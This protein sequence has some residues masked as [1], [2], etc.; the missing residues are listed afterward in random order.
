[1]KINLKDI[2]KSKT[3]EELIEFGIVNVDKPSGPTSFDVSD[4]V[5]RILGIRKTSHFGTLDPKVTG[6]LPIALNRACKLTGFFL[7]EDK[8]YVGIMRIHEEVEI[9]K[10][11]DAI[12][13]SFS[14]KIMQ[15]PPVRSR[16]ARI[17]REREIIGFELLEKEE[18][19]ILFRAEVQGGTYIR[20]LIDDLGRKLEVGAHMLELR[21]VRAGIFKEDDKEYPSVNLY[22]VEKAVE[23]YRKGNDK[24]LR[25]MIIPGE[26]VI[27]LYDVVQV[28]EEYSGKLL[29]G[30]PVYLNYLENPK[31]KNAREKIC[32]FS[33][34]K[35]IGIYLVVNE[36]DIFAKPDFV[37]QEIKG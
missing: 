13:E 20:K 28:K 23:E 6:V 33:G 5:R 32:V 1:M 25:G 7:G 10:I 22:D 15:R 9:S 16:V 31:D 30:S 29:H 34:G 4:S 35:F 11:K 18:N 24:I 19:N 8:E 26:A 27:E 3:T 36:E 12:K 14:G 37:F 2:K 17:S 21:R